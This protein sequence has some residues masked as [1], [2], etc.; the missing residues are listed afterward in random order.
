MGNQSD[1][2]P[3]DESI[4][5]AFLENELSMQR[6]LRERELA[7]QPQVVGGASSG[8]GDQSQKGA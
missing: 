1:I 5:S 4:Q 7:S 6:E 8:P 3:E 2:N